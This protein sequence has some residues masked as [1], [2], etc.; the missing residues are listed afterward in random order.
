VDEITQLLLADAQT[1]GG[2]LL[3]VPEA[4]AAEAV[5]RLH[6]AG[7]VRSAVV[8]VLSRGTG[9]AGATRIRIR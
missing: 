2:L 8:G 4:Q 3:C 5:R 6:D 7:C 1:S 9:E